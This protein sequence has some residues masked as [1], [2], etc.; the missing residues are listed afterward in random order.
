MVVRQEETTPIGDYFH[1]SGM[2]QIFNQLSST[3]DD[4]EIDTTQ[5]YNWTDNLISTLKSFKSH[6]KKCETEYQKHL[7]EIKLNSII[8]RG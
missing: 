5:L 8:N 7:N 6:I 1:D 2:W 4:F 3:V